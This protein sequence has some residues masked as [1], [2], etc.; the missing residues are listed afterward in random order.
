MF[1]L[2]VI[3]PGAY[4]NHHRWYS[5]DL[6]RYLSSE[7]LLQN[8]GF[9]GAA[10]GRSPAYAYAGNSP[11]SATDRTGRYFSSDS[12]L[13]VET[14]REMR[15]DPLIGDFV[16]AMWDDPVAEYRLFLNTESLGSSI[17]T[18]PWWEGADIT[19]KTRTANSPARC[20]ARGGLGINLRQMVAH[21]LGHAWALNRGE[22]FDEVINLWAL[23]FENSQRTA[24]PA[25]RIQ[26]TTPASIFPDPIGYRSRHHGPF[27]REE[28]SDFDPFANTRY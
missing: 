26:Q 12:P 19:I 2:L 14:V 21:E 15:N 24:T 28:P 3:L 11:L 17:T 9:V 7:P 6:G 23:I 4:Q 5:P 16:T 27:D 25:S 20:A 18:Q 13:L 22:R 1:A 8:P 10:R